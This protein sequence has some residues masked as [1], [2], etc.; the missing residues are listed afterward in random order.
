MPGKRRRF[1]L[2]A[3]AVLSLVATA[4][5]AGSRA[6]DGA[7]GRSRPQQGPA[8]P[9]AEVQ[10]LIRATRAAAT[11][12]I[13]AAD[14]LGMDSERLTGILS[15]VDGIEARARRLH[16]RALRQGAHTPPPDAGWR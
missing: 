11:S 8:S 2:V 13:S 3:C 10:E 16:G 9:D 14:S 1:L 15:R 7:A 4:A 6:G 12:A 5:A